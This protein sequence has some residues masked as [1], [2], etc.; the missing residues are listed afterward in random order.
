MHTK[1]N[2]MIRSLRQQ[3]K[4]SSRTHTRKRQADDL[5]SL[6]QL[7]GRKVVSQILRVGRNV[8]RYYGH[9]VYPPEHGG[10]TSLSLSDIKRRR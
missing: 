3:R 10:L 4:M 7:H 6:K 2:M 1:T 8:S 5:R 9:G